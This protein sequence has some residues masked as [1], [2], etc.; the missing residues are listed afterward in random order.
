MKKNWYK[1]ISLILCIIEC[2]L[3]WLF[4]PLL[5]VSLPIQFVS[6]PLCVST[7]KKSE[8]PGL[9]WFILMSLPEA[10]ILI[11]LPFLWFFWL[12]Y[13]LLIQCILDEWY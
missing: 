1:I 2:F 8:F 7:L 6:A 9:W 10:F 5:V 4:P 3:L 12:I 11:K 13:A